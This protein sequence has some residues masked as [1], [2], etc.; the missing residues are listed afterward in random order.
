M[1]LTIEIEVTEREATYIRTCSLE[2]V[3]NNALWLAEKAA[4]SR[5]EEVSER[6]GIALDDIP[7]TRDIAAPLWNAVRDAIFR[8]AL[9]PKGAPEHATCNAGAADA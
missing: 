1:K 6:A 3:M 7:P 5:N 8:A 9:P 2:R 4:R